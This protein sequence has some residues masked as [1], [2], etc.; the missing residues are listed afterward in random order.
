MRGTVSLVDF[1]GNILD[2][3]NTSLK[4]NLFFVS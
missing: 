1:K 3:F 4:F 2:C